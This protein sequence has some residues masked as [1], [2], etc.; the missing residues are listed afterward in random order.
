MRATIYEFGRRSGPAIGTGG[1]FR[2]GCCR[3]AIR[4]RSG[5]D[6]GH[7]ADGDRRCGRQDADVVGNL[8]HGG[9]FALRHAPDRVGRQRQQQ[10]R[11]EDPESRRTHQIHHR[12]DGK[13]AEDG[14]HPVDEQ[15]PARGGRHVLD[16]EIVVR[17]GDQQRVERVGRTAEAKGNDQQ[18][19]E[20]AVADD[21]D[22]TRHRP[23]Q[24]RQHNQPATVN[25]VRKPADRPLQQQAAKEYRADE[26]RDLGHGQ[27][28]LNRIDRRHAELRREDAAHQKHAHAS[29]RRCGVE[30]AQVHRLGPLERRC[31][32]HR[33]K[34][35]CKA[36]RYQHGWNDEQNEPRR[37]PGRQQRLAGEDANHL[38]DHVGRHSLAPER[39]RGGIVEP[40]FGGHVDAAE[41]EPDDDPQQGPGPGLRDGRKE[42]ER[43][44]NQGSK[45]REDPN[46][47]DPADEVGGQAAAAQEPYEI[48]RYHDRDLQRRESLDGA[49]DA[50]Q[51]ALHAIADHQ[52]RHSKQ[53]RPRR[54]DDTYH[55]VGPASESPAGA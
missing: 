24:R 42:D 55:S 54:S 15:E 28:R 9:V 52:E 21:P 7:E 1:R 48:G 11:D 23:R 18:N 13:G 35:R 38:H 4:R 10:R 33:K 26:G 19:D 2:P 40:A 36:E 37:I 6:F 29:Q 27:P 43:R 53:K 25:P 32:V 41:G 14:T 30:A 34:D 16:L 45:R 49:S 3:R 44:G 39:V 50:Q 47:P 22:D 17:I 8:A 5:R 31:R 20:A 12:A 46:V 51:R